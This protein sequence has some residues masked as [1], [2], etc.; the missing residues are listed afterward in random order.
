MPDRIRFSDIEQMPD[1]VAPSGDSA[2]ARLA[3]RSVSIRCRLSA[4]DAESLEALRY[5]RRAMLREEWTRGTEEGEPSLEDA[6]FSAF[7]ISWRV[8]EEDRER[9]L[10]KLAELL[11]R[12]NRV[13]LDDSAS[14]RG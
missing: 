7:D 12:A 11:R 10:A 5:A 8:S 9:C 1:P 13:L 2:A 6:V 14:R 3:D 4:N